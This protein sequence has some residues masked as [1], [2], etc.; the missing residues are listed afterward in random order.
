MLWRFLRF[1]NVIFSISNNICPIEIKARRKLSYK[2]QDMTLPTSVLSSPSA[3][4]PLFVCEGESSLCIHLVISLK[5]LTLRAC[6]QGTGKGW[7][8]VGGNFIQQYLNRLV[9]WPPSPITSTS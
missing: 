6:L 7:E 2:V 8:K 1:K 4:V 9:G 5:E 3:C